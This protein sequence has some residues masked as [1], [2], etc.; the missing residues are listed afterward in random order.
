MEEPM[1]AAGPET[2]KSAPLEASAAKPAPAS[3]Q[4]SGRRRS[5]AKVALFIIVGLLLTLVA[6]GALGALLAD[7]EPRLMN[8]AESESGPR[9]PSQ[10]TSPSTPKPKPKPKPKPTRYGQ[11]FLARMTVQKAARPLCASYRASI[12][13]WAAPADQY[14][15]AAAAAAR[16]PE[17]YAA[18]E[19][20]SSHGRYEGKTPDQFEQHMNQLAF[21][22]L[23]AVTRPRIT[24]TMLD[25]FRDDSL[26]VCKLGAAYL[27]TRAKLAAAID[28]S[29]EVER[30]AASVPWYPRGWREIED[31]LALQ[32]I[33]DHDCGYS[34]AY[35]WGYHVISRDGCPNGLYV[36]INI[37][38][39]AGTIIDYSNDTIGSLPA[40]Q[41]GLLEFV[42]FQD[43]AGTL[44]GQVTDSSCY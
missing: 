37:T 15:A 44:S 18:A 24:E 36:E 6:L 38:D 7:D 12:A 34:S 4:P 14:A 40:G 29:E 5:R 28:R 31:G 8:A 20:V 27:E 21:T 10:A 41:Q 26:F 13:S 19:F 42:S 22:R 9:S 43:G 3:A 39:S 35:C 17:G 11:L 23:K 32:Y 16:D 25:H 33:E 2:L 1:L 30:N